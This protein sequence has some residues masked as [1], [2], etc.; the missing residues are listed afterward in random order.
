M[1]STFPRCISS[2]YVNVSF[3]LNI[4]SIFFWRVSWSSIRILLKVFS[5]NVEHLSIHV[6][7]NANVHKELHLLIH[8]SSLCLLNIQLL[9]DL[10]NVPYQRFLLPNISKSTLI[11]EGTPGSG[12]N[13]VWNVIS[14][15][16]N[17]VR[18]S[19][20]NLSISCL[21][22]KKYFFWNS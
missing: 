5:W 8:S 19:S 18:S 2:S 12:T 16:I 6:W 7:F 17:G 11:C 4:H 20:V 14:N 15:S 13:Y 21:S 10:W 9:K 3:E 1:T 22:W